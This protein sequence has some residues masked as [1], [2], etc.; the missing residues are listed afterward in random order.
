MAAIRRGR[1]T[2]TDQ[3]RQQ[4]HRSYEPRACR[5]Y[6]HHQG[7]PRKADLRAIVAQSLHIE[8]KPRA[9]MQEHSTIILDW[10]QPV[11]VH[12]ALHGAVD[13]LQHLEYLDQ[14]LLLRPVH[15]LR[16]RTRC[17]VVP[18]RWGDRQLPRTL[19]RGLPK[20]PEIGATTARLME[21]RTLQRIPVTAGAWHVERKR[22]SE[23]RPLPCP[24]QPDEWS[25]F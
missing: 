24:A 11:C 4:R 8:T 7:V 12:A 6:R 16:N 20:R 1:G 18:E 2:P 14:Y 21:A 25:L 5:G 10:S 3:K 22:E 15:R 17:P 9:R 19:P 23:F 13:H